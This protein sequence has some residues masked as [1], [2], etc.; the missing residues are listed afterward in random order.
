MRTQALIMVGSVFRP[1][2]RRTWD[3]RSRLYDADFSHGFRRARGG[4]R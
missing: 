1:D 3:R 2:L 4:G